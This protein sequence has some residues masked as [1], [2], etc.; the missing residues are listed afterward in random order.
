MNSI[1]SIL[2]DRLL[3]Q[4]H[5]PEKAA[6]LLSKGLLL[7]WR[8]TGDDEYRNRAEALAQSVFAGPSSLNSTEACMAVQVLYC[9]SKEGGEPIDFDSKACYDRIKESLTSGTDPKRP[10]DPLY[11]ALPFYIGWNTRFEMRTGYRSIYL[12]LLQGAQAAEQASLPVS[13][14][15]VQLLSETLENMDEQIYYEYRDLAGKLKCLLD[16][17]WPALR[18]GDVYSSALLSDAVWRLADTGL[19]PERFLIAADKA[20]DHAQTYTLESNN[21]VDI[22]SCSA[23]YLACAQREYIRSRF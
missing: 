21:S 15:F 20:L 19:L 17:F 3:P 7:R 13:A 2:E 22:Q 4:V 23:L 11:A 16:R 14:E 8:S 10:D 12:R 5:L 6:V 9:L 18:Q 1:E